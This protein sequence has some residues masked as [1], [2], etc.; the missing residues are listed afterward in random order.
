M[1]AGRYR[2]L[3]T[4]GAGGMGVVYRVEDTGSGAKVALKTL[5]LDNSDRPLLLFK[6]EFWAMT[7]LRHPNLPEVFDFGT[8][9]D[10]T[11]Y[12][13]MA[14]IE[15]SDLE[16]ALPLPLHRFYDVFIQLGQ[17][18]S[19]IHARRLIHRDVKASNVRIVPE[20]GGGDRVVLMD[21]G[22]VSTLGER[23]SSAGVS[24]TA[25]YLAPEAMQGAVLDARADLF[26]LGVLA[27][28]SLTGRIPKRF[29][30]GAAPAA[31]AAS[32]SHVDLSGLTGFPPGLVRLLRKLV[33]DAPSRRPPSADLVVETLV[34][35][36]G[37]EQGSRAT[38]AQK[39]SYLA[40]SSLVGRDA[41]LQR[42]R[43]SLDATRE[44]RG[45]A[46]LVSGPAGVGKSRLLAEFRVEAQLAGVA[47]A[48]AECRPGTGSPLQPLV[49]AIGPLLPQYARDFA[50]SLRRLAP[51][52][53]PIVPSLQRYVPGVEPAPPLDDPAAEAER[54]L[55]AAAGLLSSIASLQPVV[56]AL[57]DLQWCDG[58]TLRLIDRLLSSSG[59]NGRLLMLGS[60]RSD[61]LS[62]ALTLADLLRE[63]P[64]A[65]VPLG[66]FDGRMITELLAEQFG[67][68][69]VSDEVVEG[70]LT[71]TGGN[72][73]FLHE[74]LRYMVDQ[75]LV[76][77]AAGRWRMPESLAGI[78]L[79]S[80][81]S[82]I[83][84]RRLD[85]RSDEE[86][87][88]LEIFA[89]AG[90][91]LDLWLLARLAG[92]EQGDA[93]WGRIDALRVHDLVGVDGEVI[94]VRHD[95]ILEFTYE[96]MSEEHKAATHLRIAR[97]MADARV[98][99]S[100]RYAFPDGE[101]GTHYLHGGQPGE[102][103]EFLLEGGRK[104]FRVQALDEA[105]TLLE[106]AE[107]TLVSL[108]ETRVGGRMDEV[109]DLLLRSVY[110]RSPTRALPIA[111]RAID[112]YRE[113]GWM[114]KIPAL[115]R[116]FGVPG[117]IVGLLV[118]LV[119]LKA[120]SRGFGRADFLGMMRRFLVASTWRAQGLAWSSRF[121]ES[122]AVAAELELYAPGR[123]AATVASAVAGSASL[124]FMGRFEEQAAH[125]D[126]AYELL[127]GKLK[128]QFAAYD[129]RVAV[130]GAIGGGRGHA[131]AMRSE[132]EALR[133][134]EIEDGVAEDIAP[135]L[136]E[137]V[138][139]MVRVCFHSV[140][141]EVR[142]MDAEYRRYLESRA[143][144]RP[145]EREELQHWMAW[146]AI[147]RGEFE[148]AQ[149]LAE[150]FRHRGDLSEAWRGLVRSR[151]GGAPLARM[152]AAEE[153]VAAACRPGTAS[154]LVASL[155]RVALADAHLEAGAPSRAREVLGIV[156]AQSDAPETANPWLQMLGRRRLALVAL[157][158]GDIHEAAREA[159]TALEL[160][161]TA[162]NPLQRAHALK[163]LG[164]IETMSMRH[165]EADRLCSQAAFE[166]E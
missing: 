11:P 33:A 83:L 117:L 77:F 89:A 150:G 122:L 139:A 108:G 99:D 100:D 1:L 19:F 128:G 156:L 98:T 10:G 141:G 102:A 36:C 120:R 62:R 51:V 57:D 154:T 157:A 109:Q 121:D 127:V 45:G 115:R 23:T 59:N 81:L 61:E 135:I 6:T 106:R 78:P 82:E 25:A 130:R 107:Q 143:V 136:L 95:R 63:H 129:R 91:P 48:T 94:S 142:A 72:A 27:V 79:P 73:F 119:S 152:A 110:T 34:S 38:Q 85:A 21:F 155:A 67:V 64:R 44:G 146:A 105:V 92:E 60:L 32:G 12:F 149:Q 41:D 35:L 18:L 86:V 132:P 2:V 13:T 46:L 93:L 40:T 160:A 161:T 9:P 4:L 66:P 7:R 159:G 53:L 137:G 71:R 8:L 31:I 97:T 111:E 112:R 80:Q 29:T 5:S 151:T 114:A 163:T 148:R 164:G 88:I 126:V 138:N 42:L 56:V 39:R 87:A 68:D 70:L 76:S 140:R 116:R 43:A 118:T 84:R 113:A 49:E 69:D 147:D 158:D 16:A 90:R 24:G 166:F 145:E 30:Q 123:S 58:T 3:E 20:E 22:L 103:C 50:G 153:A 134:L 144:I 74:L 47:W 75:D 54:L 55:A 124:M 96:R 162:R 133:W 104:A 14:L 165:A 17:A 15:G 26:S 52:L 101:I 28:E 125:L 131:A 65:V 37:G